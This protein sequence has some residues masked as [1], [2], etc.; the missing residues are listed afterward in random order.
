MSCS[1]GREREFDGAAFMNSLIKCSWRDAHAVGVRVGQ[2]AL[3]LDPKG[4]Y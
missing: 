3:G 4:Q 2:H 1:I